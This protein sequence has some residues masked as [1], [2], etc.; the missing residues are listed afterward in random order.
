MSVKKVARLVGVAIYWA[1]VVGLLPATVILMNLDL[2]PDA[3]PDPVDVAVRLRVLDRHPQGLGVLSKY[4]IEDLCVSHDH[5][6]WNQGPWDRAIV[7]CEFSRELKSFQFAPE[8]N[9]RAICVQTYSSEKEARNWEVDNAHNA[10][11]SFNSRGEIERVQY[12]GYCSF[13]NQ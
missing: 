5:F 10:L 13:E 7:R 8:S 12:G 11:I 2:S 6:A 1:F 3:R 9:I 4:R